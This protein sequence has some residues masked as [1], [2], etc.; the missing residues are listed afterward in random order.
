MLGIA[1]VLYLYLGFA[2]S[3]GA[4]LGVLAWASLGIGI[5]NQ[6]EEMI[7]IAGLTVSTVCVMAMVGVAFFTH[8][9]KQRYEKIG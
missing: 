4:I 8:R 3:D 9:T 7:W 6:A 2:G 1:C 5:K